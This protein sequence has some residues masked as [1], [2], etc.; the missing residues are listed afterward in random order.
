MIHNGV[1][2][3]TTCA[4][5]SAATPL[6]DWEINPD[7]LPRD[8]TLRLQIQLWISAQ[9]SIDQWDLL[10]GSQA[11]T[12]LGLFSVDAYAQFD[13]L[14]IFDPLFFAADLAAGVEIKR[15]GAN[16]RLQLSHLTAEI[17]LTFYYSKEFEVA[18]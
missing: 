3:E 1:Q 5:N 15:N 13:V 9:G 7:E 2:R 4:R 10:D 12:A 17:T 11:D 14:L 8:T 6:G 18:P 16:D